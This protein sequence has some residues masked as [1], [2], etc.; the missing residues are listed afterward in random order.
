MSE[1][2]DA[3]TISGFPQARGA[4]LLFYDNTP[5]VSVVT[6]DGRCIRQQISGEQLLM[7]YVAAGPYLLRVPE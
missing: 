7:M 4:S 1:V 3:D 5:V 2:I 6:A